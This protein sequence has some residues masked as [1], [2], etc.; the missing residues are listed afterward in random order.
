MKAKTLLYDKIAA[1]IERQIAGQVLRVGDKL[2]SLRTICEQ[3]NVS[4]TTAL[5]AYYQLE[6]KSLIES[7]PRSGYFVHRPAKRVLPLPAVSSPD[8]ASGGEL[9]EVI[10]RVYRDMGHSGAVPLSLGVPALELL[11]VAKLNKG[12][13]RATRT[14]SGSGLEYEQVQGSDH[15]RSQVAR[16]YSGE[17]VSLSGDELVVTSGCM[18]A[19]SL[20]LM[21][22]TRRGDTIA[23]ESPVYFGIL[24][25]A[26]SLGL[27]VIELPAHPQTGVEV[28][29]LKKV[30]AAG[31]VAACLLI[32]NFNNPL[33]SLMPEAHKKEV[34]RLIQHFGVP[35]IEDDIYGEVYFGTERPRS[36]RSY[37]ES[38]L[39]LWCSSVSKTLAPGYRI[40]WVAPGKFKDEVMRLK[41]YQS[42]A[43]TTITQEVI[44]DL[45]ETGR[46]AHH[47]RG[48]R[49][50]LQ[51]NAL[52]YSH[53]IAQYFPK[54]TC[55]SRPQ[56]GF[57]LWVGLAD[58]VD[59]VKLYE[60]AIKQNISIAPGSMFSLQGQ[61]H[62]C[63]R[64][65]Y[66]MPWNENIEGAL[67]K[68]GNLII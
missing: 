27:K 66:G 50:T 67:K 28:D 15:L 52:R 53:A 29:A 59:S 46:Y 32:S 40:G 26:K 12:L 51:T 9:H 47:L 49:Q 61:Y 21:V 54:G 35:L 3:Y 42:I 4:Q 43:G 58:H 17:G 10:S 2:P 65:S 22:T 6:A 39:V 16:F 41:L 7:R 1:D 25:L 18:E 48:L 14:L 31:K 62:N 64:L 55:I 45:L 5:Q 36:C 60:R 68:L 63:M 23:V 44:A 13:L 30:L 11:P 24:Q 34:V 37:D 20:S 56:G 19:L 33:G 38:G 57:M 8:G